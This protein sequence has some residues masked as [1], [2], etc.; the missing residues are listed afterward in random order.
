[1][2]VGM[3]ILL[4]DPETRKAFELELKGNRIV[5]MKGVIP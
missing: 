4:I 2:G 3:I 1:L 5:S